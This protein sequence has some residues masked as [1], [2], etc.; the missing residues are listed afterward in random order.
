MRANDSIIIAKDIPL[1]SRLRAKEIWVSGTGDVTIFAAQYGTYTIPELSVEYLDSLC[2]SLFFGN[3]TH[4][5]AIAD[6]MLLNG[7]LRRDR[8]AEFYQTLREKLKRHSIT[9]ISMESFL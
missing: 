8:F 1:T 4:Q 9:I 6:I 3:Y 2:S 7:I 5:N